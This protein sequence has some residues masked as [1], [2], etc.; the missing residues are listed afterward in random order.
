MFA[1]AVAFALNG[2]WLS[3]RQPFS[4]SVRFMPTTQAWRLFGTVPA[5]A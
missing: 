3:M 5:G 1:A 4:V 2:S